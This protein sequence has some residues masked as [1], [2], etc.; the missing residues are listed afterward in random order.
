[1]R[2]AITGWGRSLPD[3]IIPNS[4]FEAIGLETTD[5]W[6]SERTGIRERRVA[7]AGETTA[8]L[9]EAAATDAIKSAGLT[10]DAIGIFAMATT[11]PEQPIPH[12]GAIV[13]EA[14]GI[15]C[16]SFDLNTACAGFVYGLVIAHSLMASGGLDRAL[17]VGS[18]TMSR[19]V[20]PADRGT[21]IL[22]GDGA[23]AVVLERSDDDSPG[24]V[25][26]L[27][28]DLGCDGT[29]AALLEIPGGGSKLPL[30][31]EVLASGAQWLTMAGQEV[32]RRAVRAV[33]DSATLA[34]ER[35]GVTN[36]DIDWFIPHQANTRIIESACNRLHI[37]ME[38]TVVNLDRYGNTSAASIPIALSE[39]VDDGRIKDGDVILMTG[40]GAGMTWGSV[41]LR[42]GRP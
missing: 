29:A 38:R 41:V 18:E 5:A 12:T 16:A 39:A 31:P 25:G 35:A 21:V 26:I 3:A 15:R 6:I 1:M 36:A 27:G 40:F 8:T 10:P 30:T 4:Y 24:G 37:P 23:G 11:T 14:L 9:A 2:S 33:Q 32:F 22:F 19:A 28:W 42:W 13:A 34:M 17:V 7:V 20:D